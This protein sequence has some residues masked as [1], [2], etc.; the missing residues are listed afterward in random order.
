MELAAKDGYKLKLSDDEVDIIVSDINY[1]GWYQNGDIYVI[2]ADLGISSKRSQ[3]TRPGLSYLIELIENDS[4]EILYVMDQSRLF[5]DAELVEVVPFAQLC[6]KHK[7]I[8]VSGQGMRFDLTDRSHY[9]LFIAVCQF[10]GK[11]GDMI[12]HRLGGAKK[13][14]SKMGLYAG[15]NITIGY[16]V[17][18]QK[19]SVTYDHY[20]VYE[21]HANVVREIFDLALE[22]EASFTSL[23]RKIRERNLY[24]PFFE[25]SIAGYMNNRSA[26]RL[27]KRQVLD[28]Q[29]NRIGWGITKRML[30]NMISNPAYI[31]E[32]IRDNEVLDI[33]VFPAII[34][35]NL[36]HAVYDKFFSKRVSGQQVRTIRPSHPLQ[37]ITYWME[38]GE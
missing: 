33:D 2:D 15:G 10:A 20:L 30:E 1:P 28:E 37:G 24:F 13:I 17:D 31:G 6:K 27:C 3:E 8:I 14:K 19:G 9:D 11:E 18:R 25:N 38:E 29:R 4:I 12:K 7:V 21:P 32:P 35:K 5:R 26:L 22:V 16:I 34:D 23:L 36:F